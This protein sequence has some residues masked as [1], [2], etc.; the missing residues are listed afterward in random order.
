MIGVV[1]APDG[2]IK[3]DMPDG[4]TRLVTDEEWEKICAE[5]LT[6]KV[7]RKA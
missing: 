1:R 6:R 7:E 2:R 5:R 4:T 3:C